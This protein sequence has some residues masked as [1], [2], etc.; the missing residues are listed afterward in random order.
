MSRQEGYPRMPNTMAEAFCEEYLI[1][2]TEHGEDFTDWRDGDTQDNLERMG[3][4]GA[5]TLF[6]RTENEG[7]FMILTVFL[8]QSWIIQQK[9]PSGAPPIVGA[10]DDEQRFPDIIN[11]P[12]DNHRE[13]EMPGRNPSRNPSRRNSPHILTPRETDT[14]SSESHCPAAVVPVAVS[15]G[16]CL[17]AVRSNPNP[18]SKNPSRRPRQ[19]RSP[20]CQK[21]WRKPSAKNT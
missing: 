12:E 5:L 11:A 16:H 18:K 14:P 3:Q 4:A 10:A 15:A 2:W 19:K 1:T 8:D 9:P 7:C 20:E 13:L 6:E 21:P 17:Q